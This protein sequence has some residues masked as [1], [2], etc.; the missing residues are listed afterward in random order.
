MV[1]DFR[2]MMILRETEGVVGT[3]TLTDPGTIEFRD[4]GGG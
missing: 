2:D 4:F 3:R 1:S